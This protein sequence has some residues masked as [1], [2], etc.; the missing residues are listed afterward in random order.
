MTTNA[1]AQDLTRE[2]LGFGG[3]APERRDK[4]AIEATFSPEFRNRLDAWITFTA[5]GTSTVDKIVDKFIGE[6]AAQLSAKDVELELTEDAR[7]W[8]RDKGYDK[9]FGARAMDRVVQNELKR[10][11]ADAILFG[12][13]AYGGKAKVSLSEAAAAE[14]Q[15]QFE[16]VSAAAPQINNSDEED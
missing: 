9:R 6:T 3:I 15:L 7:V 4:A 11:L 12:A 13:L 1:G 14:H 8:L 5:L 16:Y 10:P 2:A